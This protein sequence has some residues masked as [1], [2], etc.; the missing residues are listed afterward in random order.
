VR[1]QG[2]IALPP[3]PPNREYFYSGKFQAASGFTQSGLYGR[4]QQI[5]GCCA[6]RIQREELFF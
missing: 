5:G 2:T 3:R 6:W 1:G 4:V